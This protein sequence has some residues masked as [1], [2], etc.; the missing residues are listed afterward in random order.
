MKMNSLLIALAVSVA[1]MVGCTFQQPTP[2]PQDSKPEQAPS[3]DSSSMAMP[4]QVEIVAENMNV[5]WDMAFAPDGRIFVTER[6]GTLRVLINGKLVGK[7]VLQLTEPFVSKGE[8]GLLGL[9]LDPDFSTNHYMYVYHSYEEQGNIQ[10]R[11]LRLVEQNNQA[12]IDKVILAGL[13]GQRNHDG[14]R[15][16]IGPDRKLY[17][18]LGDAQNP[19][20][21]QDLHVWAGKILRL[22]LDGSIPKDNPFPGS[23]V[24]SLGHRNPQ[25]LA[26]H[27]VN[28][29]LFSSEHGQ[30]S[31]DEINIIEAGG[32]YGFPL[33][34]GDE[35]EPK[36][37]SE[38]ATATLRTPL[39]HSGKDTTWAPS[40]MTFVTKG[41]WK[42]NLLVAN[43][44]GSQLL[45]IVLNPDHTT[46]KQTETVFKDKY[47]RI[48]NV[49]EAPD[50]SIYILTNNRDGRGNTNPGDDKIIK[51]K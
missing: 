44:R 11:I 27:P 41:T 17:V 13:P 18:T 4:Y 5:P 29:S 25:G 10:N 42:N 38:G 36:Q 28:G 51:L 2:A 22:E 47:G 8:S 37:K 50:G 19:E 46:I 33:I 43:L 48:R 21:S 12:K 9:A 3:A 35:S 14:G 49:M 31:M 7:P 30:S 45:R 39:V 16:R 20:W 32:N 1:M 40:G 23:P 6:S 24:Y 26:W 34:Q 15:I